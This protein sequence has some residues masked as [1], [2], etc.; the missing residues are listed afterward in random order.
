MSKRTNYFKMSTLDTTVS[1][2]E[3]WRMPNNEE[4]APH[5]WPHFEPSIAG[6]QQSGNATNS[7]FSF[8]AQPQ[9]V[10]AAASFMQLSSPESRGPANSMIEP[11]SVYRTVTNLSQSTDLVTEDDQVSRFCFESLESLTQKL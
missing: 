3:T 10:S 8:F 7:S 11:N 4:M 9:N 2:P 6:G 1:A 5:G